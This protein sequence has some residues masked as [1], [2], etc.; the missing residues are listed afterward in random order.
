MQQ[1]GAKGHQESPATVSPMPLLKTKHQEMIG[2]H[3]RSL[4][5]CRDC[6]RWYPLFP[7]NLLVKV[8]R[9]TANILY[10]TPESAVTVLCKSF[11]PIN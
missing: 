9:L 5:D 7:D 11:V 6:W 4:V 8:T 2:S 1:R 10:D 3:T